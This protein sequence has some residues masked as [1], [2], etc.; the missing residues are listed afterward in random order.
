MRDKWLRFL[1][2]VAVAAFWLMVWAGGCYLANQQLFLPL[3]YPWD[4]LQTLWRLM[5]ESNFWLVVGTSLLRVVVGFF[6]AFITGTVLAVLTTRLAVIHTLVAPIL[7]IVRAAPVA[8]FI[9]V[10]F[11]WIRAESMP[12]FISFLMVLPLVWENVRQ[13]ILHTDVKLLEMATVFRLNRRERLR[14]IHLPTIR[15][16]LQAAVSTGFGF[17]W[18]AGVAA[19]ALILP[20]LAIGTRIFEAKYNLETVDLFAWTVIVV[21]LSAIIE[22]LAHLLTARLAKKEATR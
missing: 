6:L 5:G 3:P 14:H 15:P 9:F 8:S 2:G 16:Y 11:L 17:A 13:G 7:S 22:K 18:K 10:A 20:V 1:R 12:A 19:E 21:L 4:V